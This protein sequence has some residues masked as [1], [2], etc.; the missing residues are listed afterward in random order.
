[1]FQSFLK[2]GGKC[3]LENFLVVLEFEKLFLDEGKRFTLDL[4]NFQF[5]FNHFRR[6]I[7]TELAHSVVHCSVITVGHL[8]IFFKLTPQLLKFLVNFLV[9]RL[10]L[11]GISQLKL[12]L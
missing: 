7:F 5:G 2:L 10:F 12:N 4:S 3:L 9:T 11:L 6:K 8:L 1:V